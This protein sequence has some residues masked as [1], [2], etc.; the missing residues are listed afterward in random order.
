LYS[1][2][3]GVRTALLEYGSG[4]DQYLLLR[5]PVNE[6]GGTRS[7]IVPYL[8]LNGRIVPPI[9]VSTCEVNVEELSRSATRGSVDCSAVAR[10]VFSKLRFT[11]E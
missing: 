2:E 4:D 7:D 5:V 3:N 1:Y 6:G 10:A 9:D 11:A 8:V